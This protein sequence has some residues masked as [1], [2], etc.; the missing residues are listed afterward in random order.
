V[1]DLAIL[2]EFFAEKEGYFWHVVR[3]FDALLRGFGQVSNEFNVP[4][5]L[6]H[7]YYA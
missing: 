2:K 5:C 3:F 6:T 4:L 7:H 1:G